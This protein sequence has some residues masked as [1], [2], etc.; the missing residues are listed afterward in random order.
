ME[1]YFSAELYEVDFLKL[2]FIQ[3][4][5]VTMSFKNSTYYV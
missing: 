1:V 4:K 5:S 2:L 3:T